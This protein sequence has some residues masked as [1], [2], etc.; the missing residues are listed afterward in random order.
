MGLGRSV[1]GEISP[2]SVCRLGAPLPVRHPPAMFARHVLCSDVQPAANLRGLGLSLALI[3]RYPYTHL[4]SFNN[5][6]WG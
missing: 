2:G 5:A 6:L 4:G 1:S 3:T